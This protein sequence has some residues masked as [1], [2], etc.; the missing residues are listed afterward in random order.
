M[1]CAMTTGFTF[2][3]NKRIPKSFAVKFLEEAFEEFTRNSL[4]EKSRYSPKRITC[5]A[6]TLVDILETTSLLD[7]Y[8][9]KKWILD[10]MNKFKS[11]L[12]H[13]KNAQ[14]KEVFKVRE[15]FLKKFNIQMDNSRPFRRCPFSESKQ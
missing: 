7:F 11:T 13:G 8:D 15:A 5:A 1:K 4:V 6:Q 3:E 9:D 14:E 12:I 2:K 10:L